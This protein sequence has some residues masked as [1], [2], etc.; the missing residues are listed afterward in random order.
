MMSDELIDRILAT[1]QPV[2]GKPGY[3]WMSRADNTIVKIEVL[4][5]AYEKQFAEGAREKDKQG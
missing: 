5:Q 4:R 2:E 3:V 1:Y